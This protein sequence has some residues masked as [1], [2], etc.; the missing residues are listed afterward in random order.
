M[1][2]LEQEAES[3]HQTEDKVKAEISALQA[4]LAH[5]ENQ[6]AAHSEKVLEL[7]K[8][9]TEEHKRSQEEARAQQEAMVR[10]IDKLQTAIAQANAQAEHAQLQ[11]QQILQ[12]VSAIFFYCSSFL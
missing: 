8:C 12:E 7:E 9:M 4:Q 2:Q 10:E 11:S 3:A 6:L 5:C 1:L